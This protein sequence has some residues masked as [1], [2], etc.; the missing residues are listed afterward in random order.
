M[1]TYK[2]NGHAVWP[3]RNLVTRQRW[4]FCFTTW[5]S[6]TRRKNPWDYYVEEWISLRA[7]LDVSEK[8]KN[9][10][11]QDTKSPSLQ[12]RTKLY[13]V[14]FRR[15]NFTYTS[16]FWSHLIITWQ[17]ARLYHSVFV[18]TNEVFFTKGLFHPLEPDSAPLSAELLPRLVIYLC[19]LI[20]TVYAVK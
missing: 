17:A 9:V 16:S 2:K 8:R 7:G 14:T 3:T 4:V 19:T 5:P 6:Y 11:L 15:T 12:Q 20:A 18:K 1:K 10:F 13:D